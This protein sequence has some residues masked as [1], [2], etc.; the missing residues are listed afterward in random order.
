MEESYALVPEYTSYFSCCNWRAGYSGVA[1]YCHEPDA[2]PSDAC[3]MLAPTSRFDNYRE[4]WENWREMAEENSFREQVQKLYNGRLQVQLEAGCLDNSKDEGRAVVTRYCVVMLD[5]FIINTSSPRDNANTLPNIRTLVVVNV[6]CPH[7]DETRPE[8]QEYQ[9]RFLHRLEKLIEILMEENCL[10]MVVGDFNLAPAAIDVADEEMFNHRDSLARIWFQHLLNKV[11]RRQRSMIDTFR[12]CHPRTKDAF[13]VW[14]TKLGL[15]QTN[16]GTRIDL[17]LVDSELFACVADC[18]HMPEHLG[19]DHCPV[20]VKFDTT[21]ISFG[22]IGHIPELATCNWKQFT[23]RQKSITS[24][25][26]P[27]PSA[28]K[29]PLEQEPEKVITPTITTKT[30]PP[31]EKIVIKPIEPKKAK[32]V[33]PGKTQ[34]LNF[35]AVYKRTQ[36]ASTLVD[37]SNLIEPIKANDVDPKVLHFSPQQNSSQNQK[38]QNDA[39]MNINSTSNSQE[40]QNIFPKTV[41]PPSSG[42]PLCSG[43][44]LPAVKRKVKKAGP[45]QGHEFYGCPKIAAAPVGHPETRC[46]FFRWITPL[47][48]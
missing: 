12:N 16:F 33:T 44:K 8:R 32:T 2:R 40:W 22:A 18:Y 45:R 30:P 41:S 6:Y 14:N 19:S 26:K 43:H 34:P 20:V 27:R 13:T 42:P 35:F 25:F 28:E 29:K 11:D 36:G 7:N 46:D 37:A 1:T 39:V 17:V 24:F 4:Q 38:I 31:A 47:K 23:S 9:L 15:R 3:I 5:S 48:K 21:M 10:V